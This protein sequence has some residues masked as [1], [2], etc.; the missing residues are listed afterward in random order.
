[1]GSDGAVGFGNDIALNFVTIEQGVS[2][3]AVG[4]AVQLLNPCK[5]QNTHIDLPDT[6]TLSDI[7]P[8]RCDC[9]DSVDA[10]DAATVAVVLAVTMGKLTSEYEA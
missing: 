2:V 8:P 9:K 7:E 10:P 5:F 4:L 3:Q 6:P 1:M